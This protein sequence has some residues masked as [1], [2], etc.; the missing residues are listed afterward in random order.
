[1]TDAPVRP[2]PPR[3]IKV[4]AISLVVSALLGLAAA[5]TE[6]S[7][8]FRAWAFKNLKVADHKAAVRTKNPVK[9]PTDAAIHDSIDKIIHSVLIISVIGGLLMVGLAFAAWTG[10]YWARWSIVGVWVLGTLFGALTGLSSLLGITTDSPIGYRL[11]A[12]V[13]AVAFIVSIF[14]VN[15]R[16]SVGYL[17]RNRP[18]RPVRPGR[19]GGAS[20]GLFAPRAMRA[21]DAQQ[22]RSA[23]SGPSLRKAATPPAAAP[24]KP[25]ATRPASQQ[26]RGRAKSTSASASAETVTPTSNAASAGP[27]AASRGTGRPRGKS[28]R[29]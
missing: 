16:P 25:A 20:G 7:S 8:S 1:V 6:P 28:R 21:A 15:T 13:G 9:M 3:N 12:F 26:A 17:N 2:E 18:A 22:A 24:R 10:K 29:V 19:A 27:D 4:T 23:G 11:L 14:F 5:L